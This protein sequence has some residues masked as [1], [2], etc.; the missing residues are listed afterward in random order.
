[1]KKIGTRTYRGVTLTPVIGG[2]IYKQI[3][4]TGDLASVYHPFTTSLEAARHSIMVDIT[5]GR[6]QVLDGDLINR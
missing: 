4:I 2:W 3:R 1:M 5:S 6:Y